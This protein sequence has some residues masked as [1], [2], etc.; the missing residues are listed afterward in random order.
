M[1]FLPSQTD[2]GLYPASDAGEV[3]DAKLD[4]RMYFTAKLRLDP[5]R[6][7]NTYLRDV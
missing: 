2:V 3:L 6:K 4:A 7:M 5:L 1:Q